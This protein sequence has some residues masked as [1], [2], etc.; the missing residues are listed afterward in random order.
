MYAAKVTGV[1][2]VGVRG[3]LVTVEPSAE[4]SAT[5]QSLMM[6]CHADRVEFMG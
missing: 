5:L 2:V 4:D 1:T 6:I 3:H